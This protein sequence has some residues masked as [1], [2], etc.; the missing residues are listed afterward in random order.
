[1]AIITLTSDYGNRDYFTAAIKGALLSETPNAQI[2]DI[3]HE[4]S[5]FN[6]QEA[7]YIL[8]NAYVHFP[9]GTIHM[10]GIDSE[11]STNKLHIACKFDGHYFIGADTGIFSLM[12]PHIKAEQIFFSNNTLKVLVAHIAYIQIFSSKE[13]HLFKTG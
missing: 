3:S 8:K 5:P 7:A 10:I 2:I 6:I 1:M 11:A 9:K 12:F 13:Q 4:I